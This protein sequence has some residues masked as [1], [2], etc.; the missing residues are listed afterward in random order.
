M[1]AYL[2]AARAKLGQGAGEEEVAAESRRMQRAAAG[3][4]GVERGVKGGRACAHAVVGAQ[5]VGLN[6]VRLPMLS[7]LARLARVLDVGAA[8]LLV[9]VAGGVLL[10]I[11]DPTPPI[12]ICRSPC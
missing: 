5:G 11:H 1:P 10:H 3:A 2:P 9:S 12:P 7:L 4:W 8:A 6:R